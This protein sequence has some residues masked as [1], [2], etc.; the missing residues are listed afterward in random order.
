MTALNDYVKNET[1]Q[2]FVLEDSLPK[3]QKLVVH[4]AKTGIG[5]QATISS[6]R[7]GE[8]TG[9]DTLIDWPRHIEKMWS[10]L[11]E[12]ISPEDRARARQA[13][14]EKSHGL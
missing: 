11:M 4:D 6:M 5:F 7:L 12:N 1:P 10:D 2:P 13:Y 14:P 8:D 9:M 3:T